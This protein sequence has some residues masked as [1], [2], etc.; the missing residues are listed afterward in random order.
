M[1]REKTEGYAAQKK[2]GP[3]PD[4]FRNTDGM[5]LRQKPLGA[6]GTLCHY[7]FCPVPFLPSPS[8]LRR[9]GTRWLTKSQ[10]GKDCHISV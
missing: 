9:A 7:I 5:A 6:R 3:S 10:C 2:V 1:D 4:V 8:D